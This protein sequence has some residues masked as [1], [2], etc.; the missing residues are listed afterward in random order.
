MALLSASVSRWIPGTLY[1]SALNVVV[2]HY[3]NVSHELR[4]F[5][6]SVQFDVL[7]KLYTCGCL[8]ELRRELC[9]LDVLT[10]MLKVGDKRHILHHCFQALMDQALGDHST[11]ISS[12]ISQTYVDK[13]SQEESFDPQQRDVV[14][15]Q[16]LAV[17]GFLAEA[18]WLPD[19]EIILTAC[20]SVIEHGP[21][22]HPHQLLTRALECCHRLLHVQNGYCRFEEAERT[23]NQ[24]MQLVK[25]LQV[26]GA[27]PNLASL[28]SEFSTL[29]MLRSN[30]AEAY[31]WSVKALQAVVGTFPRPPLI[32][33]LRQSAK[34]CVLKREFKKAGLLI[35]QAVMIASEVFGEEHPKYA[36]TLIDYGFYLLNVDAISQG[37]KV[38]QTA[39]DV[40]QSVFGGVNLHVAIAHEDLAYASYVHNYALGKFNQARTHAEKAIELMLRLLPEDHLLLSSS[41][42]VKALI[43]EEMA[44]DNPN[45]D[46]EKQYLEEA[47]S[48]HK[49][50]LAMA[51]RAFGE[52]N[53]QTAKHYGN[54]GRL[55]QSMRRYLLA[56]EMHLKAITIKEQLLGPEDYEVALSVGHLASLYNYDMMK[57]DQAEQLYLRS[58][59]IGKKL[60]GEGYS[61]LEYDYRGLLRVYS[62]QANMEK[63]FK[64][65]NVLAY[66]KLLRDEA[67]EMQ[68]SP[69]TELTEPLLVKDTLHKF[70]TMS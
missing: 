44:I 38:Y 19:A 8:S 43:L 4:I 11:K 7:Y 42:R 39:L 52:M 23:Y 3:K 1:N 41:K 68:T 14:V 5:P 12:V 37:V 25:R 54:L 46:V 15:S 62:I 58:I 60:F 59:A 65:Q 10:R 40:R 69:F 50:A 55:Y 34:A 13:C 47:H 66:W 35:K 33:V 18:G 16:G 27:S 29:Y 17:S 21:S 2:H 67:Q 51:M 9:D 63:C 48:L 56:E 64:Y 26:A 22:N 24:A 53:V 61:G 20:Q 49:E 70:M 30:Y 6:P 45:K 31:S 32:D 28:Y 57:F 36:D